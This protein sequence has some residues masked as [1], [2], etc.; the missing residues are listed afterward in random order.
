MSF[1]QHD[2]YQLYI[3]PVHTVF[4][5]VVLA[6]ANTHAQ[7]SVFLEEEYLALQQAAHGVTQPEVF[8]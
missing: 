6:V 4:Y 7:P 3:L 2:S 1:T 8:L 5:N